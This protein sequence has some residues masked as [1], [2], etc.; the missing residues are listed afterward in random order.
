MNEAEQNEI[1]DKITDFLSE[2]SDKYDHRD[3]CLCGL[4]SIAAHLDAAG[5]ISSDRVG[6]LLRQ[7]TTAITKAREPYEV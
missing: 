7:F 3:V 4:A 5:V 1:S 6:W 2:L